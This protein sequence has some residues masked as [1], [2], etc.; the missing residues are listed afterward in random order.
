MKS[1]CRNK[2]LTACLVL[3]A[4]LVL[5][6][7][8][9]AQTITEDQPLAFGTIVVISTG[10]VGRVTINP[11]GTYSYNSNIY[12]HSPPQLGQYTVSG[13]PPNAAYTVTL[14]PS[15]NITGP[16][17]P[18]VVDN[19]EV[20]PLS[21]VTDPTGEDQFSISARLQTL[22]GGTPYGDGVYTVNFPVTINF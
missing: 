4:F 1:Y 20:R 22:G 11:S 17:G 2:P 19:L 8:V 9:R 3:A 21:L 16:G 18:F 5:P 6:Q 15:F 14:P 10:A 12:L 13:G 7:A